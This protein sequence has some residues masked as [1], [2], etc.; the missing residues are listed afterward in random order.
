MSWS[1]I[2]QFRL[3]H[4]CNFVGYGYVSLFIKVKAAWGD[5]R[6]QIIFQDDS[7]P[8]SLS[9]CR[10]LFTFLLKKMM[11]VVM[12]LWLPVQRYIIWC[13][14]DLRPRLAAF[15]TRFFSFFLFV[16][17]LQPHIL[18]KSVVNSV[19]CT[20]YGSYSLNFSTT[21]LLKISPT[22]LFTHLKIILIQYF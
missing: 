18:T 14:F 22:I 19:L 3:H 2:C 12:W 9:V 21:F 17:L 10:C 1:W 5:I 6:F 15:F 13:G 4:F 11:A 8:H 16:F 7:S 20:V